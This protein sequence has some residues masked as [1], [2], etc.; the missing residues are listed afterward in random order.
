MKTRKLISLFAGGG[1]FTEGAKQAG[2]T[3]GG[4]IELDEKK[5]EI[6]RLNHGA[7]IQVADIREVNDWGDKSCWMLQASPPC[8]NSSRAKRHSSK[9]EK[10]KAFDL[11]SELALA[12]SRSL[13]AINPR[14]FVL[15]NVGDYA[16][17]DAYKLTRKT[18][19][20][21]GYYFREF[22]LN[23]ADFGVPQNRDRLYLIASLDG[24]VI[25]RLDFSPYYRSRIGWYEGIE[26][27]LATCRKKILAPYQVN[28]I[29]KS[30]AAGKITE[31]D[32]AVLVGGAGSN[33]SNPGVTH[34]RSP[35]PTVRSCEGM[36]SAGWRPVVVYK[37]DFFKPHGEAVGYKLSGRCLLA[38][39]GVPDSYV[40]GNEIVSCF[41][42]G[43]GVSVPVARAIVSTII[44][45]ENSY[46]TLAGGAT[47]Y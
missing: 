7:L 23:S 28:A 5:A 10:E 46:R 38:L 31:N 17:T 41:V 15:E 33:T 20:H 21:L 1:L 45:L 22:R 30:L 25:E 13:T 26:R 14:Y 44:N 39:Q 2:L 3:P 12:V 24:E 36:R 8:K 9:T 37:S 43:N 42:A 29:A 11:D 34:Y 35:S 27:H 40:M 16:A 19:C 32:I 47:V 4:A 18:L 6:Y